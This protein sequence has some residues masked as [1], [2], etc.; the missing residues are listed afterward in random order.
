MPCYGFH[1]NECGTE[2][3]VMRPMSES[4]KDEIC[5]ECG[6]PMVREF[7][8]R[9]SGGEYSRAIVSDSLA[10]SPT[11]IAE[12]KKH[13]PDIKVTPEGQPV[14]DSFKEHDAYLR[15][16]GFVKHPGKGKRRAKR[17]A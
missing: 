2:I 5:S 1:C 10:I 8:F 6:K 11:Q 16:T 12:H 13:F 9:V 17:I 15:K 3:E 7:G 14:F 4:D